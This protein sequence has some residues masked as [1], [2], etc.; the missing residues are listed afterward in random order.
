MWERQA[1]RDR[2]AM[3]ERIVEEGWGVGDDSRLRGA[4][5]LTI[6]LDDCPAGWDDHAGTQDGVRVQPFHLWDMVPRSFS[7]SYGSTL[8]GFRVYFGGPHARTEVDTL[9]EVYSLGTVPNTMRGPPPFGLVHPGAAV[10]AAG[11]R[12]AEGQGAAVELT[13]EHCVPIIGSLSWPTSQWAVAPFTVHPSSV[14]SALA[15]VVER[16]GT[17]DQVLVV[18]SGEVPWHGDLVVAGVD[19]GTDAE[20]RRKVLRGGNFGSWPDGMDATRTVVVVAD[21]GLTCLVTLSGMASLGHTDAVPVV[22]PP[23]CRNREAYLEPAGEAASAAWTVTPWTDLADCSRDDSAGLGPVDTAVAERIAR[24]LGGSSPDQFLPGC[25]Y[26]AGWGQAWLVD[27]WLQVAAELPGGIGRTNLMLAA[28]A[29][30]LTHPYLRDGIRLRTDGPNDPYPI[31]TF[32]PQRWDL[33]A[34]EWI[35]A[36]RLVEGAVPPGSE[37]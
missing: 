32:Q 4:G 21:G 5:G 7:P 14:G 19:A 20:L 23:G 35:D 8:D 12:W 11:G 13:D 16:L 29:T 9:A 31:E 1:A 18:E 10:A 36:G 37:L 15:A 27:Q 6:D 25:G 17:R 2:A 3:V 30:D 26:V 22:L 33:E 24:D 28:T 34:G